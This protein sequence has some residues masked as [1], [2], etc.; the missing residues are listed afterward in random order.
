M[1]QAIVFY[2]KQYQSIWKEVPWQP[3]PLEQNTLFCSN[4]TTI[5]KVLISLNKIDPSTPVPVTFEQATTD[6]HWA[7]VSYEEEFVLYWLSH[8]I[9]AGDRGF[10]LYRFQHFVANPINFLDFGRRFK[11]P[12]DST[13]KIYMDV[14]SRLNEWAKLL[15]LPYKYEVVLEDNYMGFQQ[16][17]D[18][19]LMVSEDNKAPDTIP[20]SENGLIET[21]T[22]FW[23]RLR[24]WLNQ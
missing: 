13:A 15:E 2:Q 7:I 18:K 20:S 24:T 23:R 17:Y 8:Y 10:V 22:S 6:L 21:K 3:F 14:F 11:L 16:N 5:R 12:D 4:D 1:K 9:E 19:L